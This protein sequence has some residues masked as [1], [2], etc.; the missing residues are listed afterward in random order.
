M[1][2]RRRPIVAVV[3]ALA[4]FVVGATCTQAGCL[5]PG[6]QPS[7]AAAVKG[8]CAAH[9]THVKQSTPTPSRG[10]G[11]KPCP[12]CQQPL[13]SNTTLTKNVAH[14]S[15]THA[16]IPFLAP[17]CPQAPNVRSAGTTFDELSEA[18]PTQRT[19]TLLALCCAFLI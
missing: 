3:A 8:C 16:V 10:N 7:G 2:S 13:F 4:V 19:P 11:S 1:R 17:S 14:L 15:L 6:Q 12:A 9:A 18:P 5:I